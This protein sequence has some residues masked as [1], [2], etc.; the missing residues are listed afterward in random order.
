M[1]QARAVVEREFSGE[2][3]EDSAMTKND[4]FK[5]GMEF[6]L[7]SAMYRGYDIAIDDSFDSG[8]VASAIKR[9]KNI[10]K[11]P[12]RKLFCIYFRTGENIL[13]INSVNGF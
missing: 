11:D 7:I 13:K 9:Y 5:E 6:L 4:L 12:E 3:E 1:A 2:S 10:L 8:V